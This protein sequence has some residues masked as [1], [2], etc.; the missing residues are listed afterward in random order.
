MARAEKATV[1]SGACGGVA[2]LDPNSRSFP[3]ALAEHL[4]VRGDLPAFL[5]CL[6][7]LSDVVATRCQGE[8]ISH[9][10]PAHHRDNSDHHTGTLCCT[11]SS[12]AT[13]SLRQAVGTGG[14][15]LACAWS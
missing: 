3:G 4:L 1:R 7:L 12:Q 13:K 9:D 10:E 2:R 11:H 14:N 8:P 5:L 6:E 15:P